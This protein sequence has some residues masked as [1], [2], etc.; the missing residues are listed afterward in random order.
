MS[1]HSLEQQGFCVISEALTLST[2]S[3]VVDFAVFEG[4]SGSRGFWIPLRHAYCPSTPLS[5]RQERPTPPLETA[6]SPITRVGTPRSRHCGRNEP[7]T[8]AKGVPQSWEIKV[9][10]WLAIIV[11]VVG[12][13]GKVASPAVMSDQTNPAGY[14]AGQGW[15]TLSHLIAATGISPQLTSDRPAS[16][17]SQDMAT[18]QNA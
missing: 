15:C 17:S 11:R 2:S 10:L 9:S 12:E 16:L 18:E 3:E 4:V 5:T 1:G 8:C 13:V 7:T 14:P 6:T